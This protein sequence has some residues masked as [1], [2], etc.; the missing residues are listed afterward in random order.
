MRGGEG[1]AGIGAGATEDKRGP[2]QYCS[3]LDRSFAGRLVSHAG[4]NAILKLFCTFHAGP[5]LHHL[6]ED[7]LLT[8]H[9]V[10]GVKDLGDFLDGESQSRLLS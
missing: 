1:G 4:E 7:S 10:Q 5:G 2:L 6:I 9:V 8:E 3:T